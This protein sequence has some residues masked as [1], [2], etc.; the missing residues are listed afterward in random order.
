MELAL[1]TAEDIDQ[2]RN[3]YR[4]VAH[5]GAIL[6]F[7]LSDIAA[8]NPMYQ[9]SLASYLEVFA[10]SLRKALPDIIVKK[11]LRNIIATLT[12]NVYE[13]GCTGES[14]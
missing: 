2:L 12:N 10:F 13:Y 8:V 3:G 14:V 11:R 9:Y 6:F 4:P 7:L 1:K 5:R